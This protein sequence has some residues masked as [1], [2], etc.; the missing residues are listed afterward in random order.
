MLTCETVE[1]AES[2]E[3]VDGAARR[4]SKTLS[5]PK[6]DWNIINIYIYNMVQRLKKNVWQTDLLLGS[7]R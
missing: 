7:L 4:P 1:L 6:V 2:V 5:G 3:V